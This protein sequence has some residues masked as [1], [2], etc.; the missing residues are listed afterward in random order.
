MSSR[1]SP[2]VV[3]VLTLLL[4]GGA[5][6]FGG[7]ASP[8]LAKGAAVGVRVVS[9]PPESSLAS[10]VDT[11]TWTSGKGNTFPGAEA[12]FGMVQWSPDTK[13]NDR[14]GGGYDRTDNRLSGYSL[15]HVSGPG[16]PAAG[17]VPI[18]PL[19]GPLPTGN[20]NQIT[21][22]FSHAGE[23]A[24]AGYYSAQSDG[25]QTITSDFTATPH[26][27]MARFTY[28]KTTRADF[29]IKLMASQAGDHG[30]SVQVIGNNEIQGSDTS[31]HFCGEG[32]NGGQPQLYT[33]YFD[34]V[35][36]RPFT[37]SQVIT[38]AG[39]SA[40]A[41]VNLTFNT[42]QEQVIRAKVGI[43]YV[44]AADAK[45]NWVKENPHWNFNTVRQRTQMT[46]DGLLGRIRVGGGSHAQTQEFYS[47]LYKDFL[48]PNITSDVNGQFMGADLKVHSLA[49]G[50]RNQYGM[51]SG[52]DTYHSLAQL[53]A[54]LD[55]QAAGDMA[56]SQ[57]NYYSEDKI[58]QQWGYDNLN[59]YVM[60]GDPADALIADY[61]TFG[62]HNFNTKQALTDMLTQAMT[63]NDVRPGEGLEQAYGFLPENGIYGCCRAHGF[64][65]ALLEYDTAD[66]AL[67]QFAGDL[68]DRSAALR[69]TRRANNWENLFDPETDLLTAR[70]ENGLFEPNVTP[71]FNGAFLTD[72]EP[73]VEGDP[74]EYLWDV[75]N[76]YSALFSLLGGDAKVQSMLTRYLS[77]PNGYGIYAE[78][79]NEFDLGEQFALDYA[80]YPAGTQQ[81]VANARNTI[82]LPGPDGLDN[83]DDLGA[84]SST[85]IWEML[86]MYPENPGGDTMVF[87]SPGFPQETIHLGNGRWIH[88]N[89]PGASPSTYYVNSLRLNG[90]PHTSPWVNY[91]RL[92]GGV[93]L[94]WTL[95]TEP[96]P[97]GSAPA[98]APP[99]YSAGLRPVVGFLSQQHVTLAPG[100]SKNFTLGAQDATARSQQVR[101]RVSAPAGSGLSISPANGTISVE[102]DG[103]GTLAMTLRA[104]ASAAPDSN[105]VTA[106]VT[107][108]GAATQTLKLDVQVSR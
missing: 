80:G 25:A 87:A 50:Q 5:W 31:G 39:Q 29:L 22:A 46:W 83:N 53:Q 102:P 90:T 84:I 18:L 88:I 95:G 72:H 107:T 81:A 13:P 68:G 35:F 2:R 34:I 19:T 70:L 45:L 17:D 8:A 12:P 44:S 43:S 30:D 82:Y 4:L 98:D 27:A 63:V 28:P 10:L 67:A 42:T 76:D 92:A 96:T 74:Y 38:N 32:N 62:A 11:R 7:V 40:P 58:L 106:S 108:P 86:G 41:A 103:R 33:V 54:M 49:P 79:T 69:L 73:Y 1:P 71:T 77:R 78:L 99:S 52:W 6:A 21:T 61:Y 20:P 23:V 47:L 3:S 37:A 48:E 101:V 100:S 15:T 85:F 26:S 14:L 89:A 59:N 66:L 16:C 65:S 24:Q 104:R 9:S 91:S 94:D 56:E 64:T 75:P 97:W 51:F 57:L 36:D 55:P 93:T 105:W 60:V